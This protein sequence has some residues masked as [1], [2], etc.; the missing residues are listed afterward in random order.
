M[1][2]LPFWKEEIM[3]IEIIVLPT[4]FIVGNMI[5]EELIKKEYDNIIDEIS[6]EAYNIE[7]KYFREKMKND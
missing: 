4:I 2:I 3:A 5:V 6:E 1:K 7:Q